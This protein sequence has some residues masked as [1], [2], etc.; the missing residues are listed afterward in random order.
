MTSAR[1]LASSASTVFRDE[2]GRFVDGFCFS[3]D[4]PSSGENNRAKTAYAALIFFT[5]MIRG[6]RMRAQTVRKSLRAKAGAVKRP[7]FGRFGYVELILWP[8]E[9]VADSLSAARRSDCSGSRRLRCI[10]GPVLVARRWR[11]VWIHLA[12]VIWAVL[13]EFF[14]WVCPLTPLENWLRR[15]GG[16]GGYSSDF[17]AHYILPLLYPEGLTRGVQ[18]GLGVFVILINAAIYTWCFRG[19][20]TAKDS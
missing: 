15:R 20:R 9:Y 2:A 6:G 10:C 18:I 3:W 19:T 8:N 7:C 16:Q 12:A 5:S 1:N 14:G 13:V 4:C 11:L 17:V